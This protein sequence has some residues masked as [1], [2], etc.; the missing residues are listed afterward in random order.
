MRRTCT[1]FGV[2]LIGLGALIAGVSPAAAAA[3][4]V[5]GITVTAHGSRSASARRARRRTCPCVHRSRALAALNNG[6]ALTPPMGWN[7]YNHYARSV[8]ASIVEAQARAIVSSGMAAAGYNY[9]NLDGGWDLLARDANGALQPD[10]SKFPDGIAPVAAYVHSLG[11]KFGIYASVG[12]TNCSGTGA[13][14][15]GHYQQDANTFASWAST[16]SRRT[17]APYP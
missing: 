14:S 8:T 7:G 12:T 6:L 1:V 4:T 17:G 3:P 2:L 13:G 15:Y 11:L 9:V 5:S 16:S 10:P